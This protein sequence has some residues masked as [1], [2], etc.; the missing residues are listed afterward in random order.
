MLALDAAHVTAITVSRFMK[1]LQC[2]VPP[3]M[4][5]EPC[6]VPLAVVVPKTQH[7]FA[8]LM[9][10]I[11]VRDWRVVDVV[12][13]HTARMSQE[14]M[15]DALM[16]HNARQHMYVATAKDEAKFGRSYATLIAATERFVDMS[17][18]GT[19]FGF[20]KTAFQKLADVIKQR[21]SSTF[22]SPH[23]PCCWSE[24][25]GCPTF[26]MQHTT[27]FVPP[28]DMRLI[29]AGTRWMCTR[30]R[31][32]KCKACHRHV[33][34]SEIAATQTGVCSLCRN[35]HWGFGALEVEQYYV[36]RA[37]GLP[38][39]IMAEDWDG[40]QWVYTTTNFAKVFV[41]EVYPAP[42]LAS[43]SDTFHELDA[44][45]KK[46]GLGAAWRKDMTSGFGKL[47]HV[48]AVCMPHT[49]HAEEGWPEP[50]KVASSL[51]TVEIDEDGDLEL[52]VTAPP[53]LLLPPPPPL[54]P[55]FEGL[56]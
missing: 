53:P 28:G 8:L 40:E 48:A 5:S 14:V 30:H 32:L 22:P 23:L 56:L 41:H 46:R 35:K 42:V 27:H 37:T 21:T 1:Q 17:P 20:V 49:F 38:V 52:D 33:D 13:M 15:C 3:L 54:P 2:F 10:L 12:I 26:T 19:H 25:V 16:K 24:A 9:G 29:C 45:V 44:E 43:F 11:L 34:M 6:I 39:Q 18:M 51:E 47:S 31:R 50:L 4:P 55:L 7:S 36:Q